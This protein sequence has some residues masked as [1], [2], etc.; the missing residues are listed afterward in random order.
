M[1]SKKQ[2]AITAAVLTAV[3]CLLSVNVA[4]PMTIKVIDGVTGKPAAGAYVITYLAIRE[5]FHNRDG[6]QSLS[7]IATTDEAGEARFGWHFTWELFQSFDEQLSSLLV[8][9]RE[10]APYAR[11]NAFDVRFRGMTVA[12]SRNQEITL[13]PYDLGG[14][15]KSNILG[16]FMFYIYLISSH[17]AIFEKLQEE[18]VLEQ[19]SR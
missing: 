11:K 19:K 10:R 12:T 2:V 1:P 7:R 5:G 3:V 9:K 15:S 17:E 16:G 4:A 14:E 18:I 8:F 6:G 13:L